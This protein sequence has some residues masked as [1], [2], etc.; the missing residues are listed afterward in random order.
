M[1]KDKKPTDES[2]E[3][4]LLDNEEIDLVQVYG[5][6]GAPEPQKLSK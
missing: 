6:S 5:K 1:K 3:E 2:E 4:S